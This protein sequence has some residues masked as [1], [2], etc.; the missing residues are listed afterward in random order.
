MFAS[1]CILDTISF[2]SLRIGFL[3]AVD[4]PAAED[5]IPKPSLIDFLGVFL[6]FFILNVPLIVSY[7]NLASLVLSALSNVSTTRS[8]CDS[9]KLVA[10]KILLT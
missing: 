2:D 3:G 1:F 5:A 9:D 10:L 8:F 7:I 4:I 6:I